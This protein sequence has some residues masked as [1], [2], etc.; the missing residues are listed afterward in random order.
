M[1][2]RRR[3]PALG[4]SN[5]FLVLVAEGELRQAPE[6]RG[7]GAAIS[8][9]VGAPYNDERR[10]HRQQPGPTADPSPFRASSAGCHGD[11]GQGDGDDEGA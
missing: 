1:F 3:S 2:V 5:G 11:V 6:W 4:P 10:E 9:R 8:L 7:F